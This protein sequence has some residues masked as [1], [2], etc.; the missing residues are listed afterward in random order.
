M[1]AT[2]HEGML[3]VTWPRV[4]VTQVSVIPASPPPSPRTLA[5]SPTPGHPPSTNNASQWLGENCWVLHRVK[6]L[7]SFKWCLK[8]PYASFTQPSE[9][10][11]VFVSFFGCFE[12]GTYA[13]L[14]VYLMSVCTIYTIP[15]LYALFTLFKHIHCF[16]SHY[17]DKSF[18]HHLL[19]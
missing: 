15:R 12:S 9:V 11:F 3:R 17:Y 6:S 13:F 1:R 16:L 5:R 8:V 18:N 2:L 10:I 4:A 19:V 7:T 14:L